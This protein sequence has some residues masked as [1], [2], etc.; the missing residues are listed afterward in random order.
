MKKTILIFSACSALAF[1]ALALF[2][3]GTIF[4]GPTLG[5]NSYQ[6]TSDNLNYS[7]G[8]NNIRTAS[9]KTYTL[10]MGPQ[11]GVFVT[12]H[13]VLGGSVNY[14]LSVRNTNTNASLT[15]NNSITANTKTNTS[16]V[17]AGPFARYYYF[18]K[19]SKTM[20]Y[21]QLN[22]TL[23]TGNGGS[24]GNGN[25]NNT[26]TYQSNGTI[27][28][29]FAWNAGGSIGFTYFFNDVVGMDMAV[30]Y[31]YTSTTSNDHNNTNTTS[32][33]SEIVTSAPNNYKEKLLTHGVTLGL[34]FHWFF[35]KVL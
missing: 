2:S 34:G 1:S 25:N 19:L 23:G 26:S 29:I 27:N 28:G 14:S 35:R 8:N 31:S 24:S 11:V 20:F 10:T 12:D 4:V 7:A 22:G 13:L 16:T 33:V 21:A 6:T 32:N 15:N 30:G 3:K 17:N 18:D 9:T 5:T